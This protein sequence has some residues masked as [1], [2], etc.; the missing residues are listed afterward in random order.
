MTNQI[1]I[2]QRDDRI[3]R[4]VDFVVKWTIDEKEE[5]GMWELREN[6]E[7]EDGE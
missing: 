1:E 5:G 4:M 7:S 6:G 2:R 3:G